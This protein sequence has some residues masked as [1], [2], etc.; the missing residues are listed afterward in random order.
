M[1]GLKNKD[2]GGQVMWIFTQQ[3][4]LSIVKHT[5]KAI[6]YREERFLTHREDIR[7]S[8]CS[9]D[10]ARDYRFRAELPKGSVCGDC[11]DDL[12]LIMKTSRLV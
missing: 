11:E 1:K 5:D 6:S 2:E 3:G 12:K 8:L 7:R 10:P 4:F 9:E